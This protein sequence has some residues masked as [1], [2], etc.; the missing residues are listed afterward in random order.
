MGYVNMG[1]GCMLQPEE[2]ASYSMFRVIKRDGSEVELNLEQD[3]WRHR[4]GI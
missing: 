3:Q 4:K 2:G 1:E